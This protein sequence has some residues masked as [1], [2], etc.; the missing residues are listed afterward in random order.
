MYNKRLINSCLTP[1]VLANNPFFDFFYHITIITS[2]YCLSSVKFIES[3]IAIL[4]LRRDESLQKRFLFSI[5]KWNK[6]RGYHRS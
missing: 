2:G 4:F 5:A 1:I 6:G 3:G